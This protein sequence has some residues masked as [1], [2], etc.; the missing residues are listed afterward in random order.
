MPTSFLG[1]SRNVLIAFI[2]YCLIIVFLLYA[3]ISDA[4]IF[5]YINSSQPSERLAQ[6]QATAKAIQDIYSAEYPTIHNLSW[7]VTNETRSPDGVLREMVLVNG[8]FP[9]PIIRAK[10]GDT[11]RIRVRNDLAMF[12][13]STSIHFHGLFQHGINAMDGVPGVT[14]CGIPT[15][16]ELTYAFDLKQSGTFWWHSHSKLQRIDGMFGGLVVYDP[17]E[18]YILGRDYD[19]EI[20]IVLHDHYHDVGDANLDWYLSQQSAG[21]EPVPDNGLI[22]GQGI[23][24]CS[25]IPKRYSCTQRSSLPTFQFERGKKYRLRILNS[26]AFA[27]MSF[28]IDDHILNIIEVDSTEVEASPTYFL[29]ISPGQRYSVI[30]EADSTMDSVYM[31]AHMHSSCFRYRPYGYQS[32]F[33]TVI[34]YVSPSPKTMI[35]HVMRRIFKIWMPSTIPRSSQWKDV[36][37][38]EECVDLDITSL[39][40]KLALDVPEAD[41]R[42]VIQPKNMQFDRVHL[43][44]FGFINRTSFIPAVGAPNLQVALGFVNASDTVPVPTVSG[45]QNTAIWGGDQLVTE[46]PLGSAV[47]LIINNDDEGAHPFHLHGYDFWVLRVFA[48]KKAGIGKWR[49]EYTSSYVLDNPIR[50]DVVTIPRLGHAVIRFKADNPGIWAFHCHIAWHIATGM[51]MQFAVGVDT[52]DSNNVTDDMLEHCR[53]ERELGARLLRPLPGDEMRNN[54]PALSY[55]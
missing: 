1:L 9:G 28:S 33:S 55:V 17:E 29:S 54:K 50:R 47:E 18:S 10:K 24:N 12:N 51:M 48:E 21:F 27:E 30:V 19:E 8:Q 22:N 25:R 11:L 34:E 13:Q 2:I 35:A 42:Y 46:I 40:P 5:T 45:R 43:A 36:L 37:P 7:R 14:Q 44:P 52:I 32:D 41:V 20:F 39:K 38:P 15:G 6:M 4:S 53:V 23:A 26:S 3:V 49:P 16:G 31:R